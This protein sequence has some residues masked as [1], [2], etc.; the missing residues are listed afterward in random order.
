MAKIEYKL[1]VIPSG[2]LTITFFTKQTYFLGYEKSVFLGETPSLGVPLFPKI[3]DF[4]GIKLQIFGAEGA[5]NFEKYRGSMKKLA[6]FG[7]LR[8]N[9]AKS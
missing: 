6:I 1:K 3:R 4:W 5:E 2:K 7:I 8:E 9:L